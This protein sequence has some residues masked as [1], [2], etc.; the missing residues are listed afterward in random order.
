MKIPTL[1]KKNIKTRRLIPKAGSGR[2]MAGK[3]L[4]KYYAQRLLL[5]SSLIVT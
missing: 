4:T 3:E 1:K 2:Q 5:I